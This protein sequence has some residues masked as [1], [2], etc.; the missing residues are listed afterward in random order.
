MLPVAECNVTVVAVPVS[1]VALILSF[2][3]SQ[4]DQGHVQHR[5]PD[6]RHV[7]R[8]RRPHWR[9]D[10]EKANHAT[11]QERKEIHFH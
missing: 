6:H 11:N 9:K 2:P 7:A 10:S 3:R 1:N 4:G 8:G 5:R